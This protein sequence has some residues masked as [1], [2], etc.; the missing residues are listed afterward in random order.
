MM[1]SF[2]NTG[3]K[4]RFPAAVAAALSYVMAVQVLSIRQESCTGDEPL[5]LAA[6]YSYLKTGDFRMNPEHPPLAKILAALPLLAFRPSLPLDSAAWSGPDEGAFGAAFFRANAGKADDMLFAARMTSILL[7]AFLGL[8][9]ALW[10][11]AAF[12]VPAAMLALTLFCFD[13]TVT[14]YGR[15]VKSDIGVTLFSFLACIAWAKFL[16]N[17]RPWPFCL[18]GIALGLALST[19]YSGLFLIPVFAA[20][21]VFSRWREPQSLS[22]RRGIGALLL[23]VAL[24]GCVAFL[25]YAP[26]ALGHHLKLG[27]V[28]ARMVHDLF[29][30]DRAHAISRMV[31]RGLPR[32]HP[33]FEGLLVLLDHNTIGHVAY[34][35]G[36]QSMYGW[37]YYFPLAFAV[38]T[39][40]AT[41]GL[42]ALGALALVPRL[43]LPGSGPPQGF[44]LLAAGVP[45]LV[46]LGFAMASHLDI[47]IRYLLPVWPFLLVLAG[48]AL[49]RVRLPHKRAVLSLLCVGL[50][51]ESLAIYP[52]YLA[53]FNFLAGGPSRGPQILLDSNI[54]WGQD[55]KK[56]S[57][58]VA[59][60]HISRLCLDYWGNADLGRLGLS[61][62]PLPATWQTQR[63]D[64]VDCTGAISV[65]LL[66]DLAADAR[67]HAWLR[68]LKPVARSGYSIYIY[69]LRKG[70]RRGAGG[71]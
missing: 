21:Y 35:L 40:A 31:S 30:R 44:P 10:T 37:W 20:L 63:R 4:L 45:I 18:A 42:L 34:L 16:R 28:D 61:G 52:H 8:A 1:R 67:T 64:E 65:N 69:D 55:A 46:F 39:P 59:A 5:E 47:G 3:A 33:Y 13:P 71:G 54:D 29:D 50:A 36:A 32:A 26:L 58:W 9:I 14:A 56:L 51:V 60:H 41:L 43:R 11:R 62:P 17:P 24:A 15:Y 19:K 6:G 27:G 66:Y 70:S 7:T 12:G 2:P 49:S 57:L 23:V 48:A 68:A 22:W 38:K 53:F 25:M